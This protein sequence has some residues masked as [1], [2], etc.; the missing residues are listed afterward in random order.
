MSQKICVPNALILMVWAQS[1]G[2]EKRRRKCHRKSRKKISQK[3]HI[4]VL[5][6]NTQAPAAVCSSRN[7]C[8]FG[9]FSIKN[10]DLRKKI[11]LAWL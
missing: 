5:K 11:F 3:C 4:T 8:K 2:L 1:S 10:K 9:I 7:S 6:D